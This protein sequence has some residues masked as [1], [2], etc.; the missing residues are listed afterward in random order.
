MRKFILLISSFISLGLYAATWLSSGQYD[1]SWYSSSKS[2]FTIITAKQ[3]AGIAYLVNNGYTTFSG[4]TIY[5]GSDIDLSG[6]TW[7]T[8]GNPDGSKCFQGKLNG[9]GH[10]IK[11][12]YIN[13]EIGNYPNYGLFA[14]LR[15]A[16]ISNLICKGFVSLDYEDEMYKVDTKAGLLVAYAKNTVFNNCASVGNVTYKRL[17]TQGSYPYK[18]YLGG[19]AG[20]T[21]SC[22]ATSCSYEGTVKLTLGVEG[23]GNANHNGGSVLMGGIV[24]KASGGTFKFCHTRSDS[25]KAVLSSSKKYDEVDT[26]MGGIV[27][28]VDPDTKFDACYSNI[29]KFETSLPR[30]TY[31]SGSESAKFK[32]GGITSYTSIA[33]WE[34]GHIYNCYSSCGMLNAA[35]QAV[36]YGGICG[37]E[38]GPDNKFKSNYS[39]SSWTGDYDAHY[40]ITY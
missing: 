20:E 9:Q 38:D 33:S 7:V 17:R 39:H 14:Q 26:Y 28:F 8:V 31:G 5:L 34:A 22:E 35:G 36:M 16:E 19:I 15:N 24:G 32:V 3:F 37:D 23:T 30:T 2:E 25:F 27:G 29:G 10:T 40:V 1:T 12:F 21:E 13:L 4:K 18:V 11:G 6:N